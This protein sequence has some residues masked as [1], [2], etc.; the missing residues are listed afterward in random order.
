V[1]PTLQVLLAYPFQVIR[2]GAY[3]N[4]MEPVAG[5]FRFD[6]LDWQVEAAEAAGK[7]NHFVRWTAK[8]LWL[9]RVFCAVGTI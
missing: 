3:W 6:E 7:A 8:D 4:R 9:P 1:R 2:L 5:V